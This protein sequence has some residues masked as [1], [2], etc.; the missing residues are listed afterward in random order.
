MKPK[1]LRLGLILLFHPDYH[2]VADNLCGIDCLTGCSISTVTI[3]QKGYKHCFSDNGNIV[4]RV[5]IYAKIV[6]KNDTKIVKYK[7]EYFELA[8]DIYQKILTKE[9]IP[10]HDI[11]KEL[12]YEYER[13]DNR[14]SR[15]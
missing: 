2:L 6:S 3:N 10:I 9:Y 7:T 8:N 15:R 11:K 4:Y 12:V 1:N 14:S 5:P 13:N